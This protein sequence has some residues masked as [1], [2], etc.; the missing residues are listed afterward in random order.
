MKIQYYV[1]MIILLITGCKSGNDME[2]KE[3]SFM[4]DIY[5][6][7]DTIYANHNNQQQFYK[8]G[9]SNNKKIIFY[10]DGDCGVCFHKI[11]QW[12]NFINN[13]REQINGVD[14]AIVIQTEILSRLEYNLER[15]DNSIPIYIDTTKCFSIYNNIPAINPKI[16]VLD[17]QN[18]V[19][20]YAED[21]FNEKR[22][23]RRLK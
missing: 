23:L 21:K 12:Q 22:V 17:E 15:I 7:V 10:T 1:V 3:I 18:A 8:L 14:Y 13:Y 9:L 6:Y 16:L 19:K 11:V 20:Y 2:G 5:P 4:P